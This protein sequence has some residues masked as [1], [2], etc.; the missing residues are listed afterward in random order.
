VTAERPSPALI[1]A[2]DEMPYQT[3]TTG[4]RT[5][6]KTAQRTTSLAVSGEGGFCGTIGPDTVCS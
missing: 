3:R 4:T 5:Q 2:A 1:A 6:Q